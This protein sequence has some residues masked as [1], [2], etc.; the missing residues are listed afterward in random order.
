MSICI[1]FDG[2][3]SE[4]ELRSLREWLIDD[5]EMRRHAKIRLGGAPVED[6]EMGS[7]LEVIEL[8]TN[9]GFQAITFALA[10]VSWRSTRP[11]KPSATIEH[12]GMKIVLSDGDPETVEKIV[13]MLESDRS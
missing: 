5:P 4:Q 6:G 2:R 8:I 12:N 3:G 11:A 9:S 1:Q 7:A 13:R 10:Y